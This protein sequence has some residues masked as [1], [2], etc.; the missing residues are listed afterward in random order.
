MVCIFNLSCLFIRKIIFT[1][2]LITYKVMYAL[3]CSYNAVYAYYSQLCVQITVQ[4]GKYLDFT[5]KFL[6]FIYCSNIHFSSSQSADI[7]GQILYTK[8]CSK[9]HICFK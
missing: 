5:Y 2:V 6:H 7:K 4:S 3:Y 9:K 1:P 8:S